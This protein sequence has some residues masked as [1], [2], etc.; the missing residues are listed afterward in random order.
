MSLW[1]VDRAAGLVTLML[2]TASVALGIV[3]ALRAH[4][5]RWPR[6]AIADLHRNLGLLALV[7]GVVHVGTAVV[8]G[9]VDLGWADA[10]IPFGA[11]YKPVWVGAGAIA[12]DLML[13]V[14]ISSGLRRR[15]GYRAWRAVH[16]L[17][18]GS[19]GFGLLHAVAIGTDT[20]AA[21]AL[22]TLAT[23]AGA[24]CGLGLM[25]YADARARALGRRERRP[26]PRVSVAGG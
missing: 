22:V 1:Y 25:R 5:N 23:C 10:L 7:F 12:A 26:R 9:Y 13:A 8:D 18:Y 11:A 21:W 4:S 20:R 19:W 2:L 15:M 16:W 24:V 14:L 6:F 3:A 17:S